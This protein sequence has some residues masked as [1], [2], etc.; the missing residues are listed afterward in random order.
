M[1]NPTSLD[2]LAK[3]LIDLIFSCFATMTVVNKAKLST[4]SSI[5]KNSKTFHRIV[6]PYLHHSLQIDLSKPWTLVGP[7]QT[8]LGRVALLQSL[9]ARPNLREHI[10]SLQVC[11]GTGWAGLSSPSP[12]T[13][14]FKHRNTKISFNTARLAPKLE[15]MDFSTIMWGGEHL[16]FLPGH[17]CA[18]IYYICPSIGQVTQKPF[19]KL[20]RLGV[21]VADISCLYQVFRLSSLEVTN[22]NIDFLIGTITPTKSTI[23]KWVCSGS[24]IKNITILTSIC[25]H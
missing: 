23:K 13:G 17:N 19:T 18:C 3:E 9:R 11:G 6:E 10:K 21:R 1:A 7:I 2:S 12:T 24:P 22:I 20:R 8:A 25:C 4:L 16:P 14:G 5:S 15:H